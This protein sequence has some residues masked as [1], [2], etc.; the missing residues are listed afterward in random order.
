MEGIT[1][2]FFDNPKRIEIESTPGEIPDIEQRSIRVDRVNR[3]PLLRHLIEREQ[4]ERVLVFVGRKYT[5]DH[6]ADKLHRN[7]I[8]A[9]SL[10]GDLSQGARSEVPKSSGVGGVKG[11][12][13]SKK[14]KLREK[15]AR[16]ERD[17]ES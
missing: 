7:G 1:R 2:D 5:A 4:W 17:T 14:D 15:V 13:K 6:V 9:L 12:R 11:R 3:T 10:H 16:E 8:E